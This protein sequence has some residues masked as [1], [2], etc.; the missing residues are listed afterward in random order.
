MT[1]RVS[2]GI[3]ADAPDTVVSNKT[4]YLHCFKGI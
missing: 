3:T 1:S 4:N 2:V